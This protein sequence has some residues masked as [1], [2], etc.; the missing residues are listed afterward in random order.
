VEKTSSFLSSSLLHATN[1]KVFRELEVTQLY[2][3]NQIFVNCFEANTYKATKM[4]FRV[5]IAL[6]A[7]EK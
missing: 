3:G 2:K 7:A 1:I 5:F 6:E 4:P